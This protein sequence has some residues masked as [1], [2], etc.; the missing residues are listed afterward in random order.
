MNVTSRASSL[1]RH[2]HEAP[3]AQGFCHRI[4]QGLVT[5]SS[6]VASF[7]GFGRF[8][9]L[10][11]LRCSSVF[12]LSRDRSLHFSLVLLRPPPGQLDPR[13]FRLQLSTGEIV[14]NDR[15]PAPVAEQQ[16]TTAV[17]PLHIPRWRPRRQPTR[18]LLSRIASGRQSESTPQPRSTP[19]AKRGSKTRSPS[20]LMAARRLLHNLLA[21]P[22]S[23]ST[24]VRSLRQ[25]H[26]SLRR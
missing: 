18:R 10:L 22:P 11:I 9:T 7:P 3:R 23:S 15:L 17:P 1:P 24:M 20:S 12:V 14:S 25:P 26:A 19:C 4:S 5:R 21:V 13:V 2:D 8:Q 16:H 6:Q